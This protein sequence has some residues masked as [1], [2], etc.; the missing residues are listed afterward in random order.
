MGMTM[1]EKS[2]PNMQAAMRPG[3]RSG[4]PGGFGL[5]NDIT[6]PPAIAEFEKSD[7]LFL[8]RIRLR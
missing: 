1:T 8:I 5:A 7:V 2:W 4:C 6:G 3:R